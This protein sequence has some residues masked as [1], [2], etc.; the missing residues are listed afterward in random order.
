LIEI[1][2]RWKPEER[3]QLIALAASILASDDVH[4][5]SRVAFLVPVEWVVPRLRELCHES[6][7]VAG[8]SQNDFIDLLQA[9]RAIDGDRFWGR[10]LIYLASGEF[11]AICPECSVDLCV[12]IG[13]HGIFTTAEEWVEGAGDSSGTVRTRAGIRCCPIELN[14]SGL[15]DEGRWLVERAESAQQFEVA[16]WIRYLYGTSRCPACHHVFDVRDAIAVN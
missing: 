9:A 12:V 11:P 8:L 13:K 4:G 5:G 10:N 2:A 14:A 3:A 16:D 15:P 7:A 1:A 6:L